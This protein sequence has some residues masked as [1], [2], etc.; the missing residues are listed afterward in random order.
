MVRCAAAALVFAL[1][2]ACADYSTGGRTCFTDSDC[3]IGSTCQ[4]TVCQLGDTPD[5][6]SPDAFSD[7]GTTD[8][9]APSGLA[10]TQGE[11]GAVVLTWDEVPGAATYQVQVDDAEW[12]SV[13][14]DASWTDTE[15][16]PSLP[17]VGTPSASD[18]TNGEGIL[19]ELPELT[20]D[21]NTRSYRVR[22]ADASGAVG[23]ETLP[24][25]GYAEALFSVQ[26][27][28]SSGERDEAFGAIEGATTETYLDRDAPAD[29]ALRWY[30]V[31]WTVEGVTEVSPSD[32]GTRARGLN[33]ACTSDE[34][35]GERCFRGR[36]APGAMVPVPAGSFEMGASRGDPIPE[37]NEAPR[38]EVT[39][40]PSF[41]M[42]EVEV[43]R[44]EWQEVTGAAIG[45]FGCESCPVHN[46]SIYAAAAFANA[47][48]RRDAL[49]ECYTFDPPS[50]ADSLDDWAGGAAGDC[51]TVFSQGTACTGYRLPNEVE[52]EYAYR[53]G[54]SAA[55]HNGAVVR[56]DAQH[57]GDYPDA[58][59]IASYCNNSSADYSNCTQDLAARGGPA[60][61]GVQEVGVRAPN[62]WGLFDM[63]G[64]V[65]EFVWAWFDDYPIDT[66]EERNREA[67][68]PD[69]RIAQR[70][71][72]WL[73]DA[74]ELRAS[75]RREIAVDYRNWDGG[76]RLVRSFPGIE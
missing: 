71:G 73:S 56:E 61:G 54:E 22:A 18:G 57:C 45:F 76:F 21:P 28:R 25:S 10:A 72:A 3:P 75:Y 30:R 50:C 11:I 36:C 5:G 39:V 37:A 12:I 26:W 7:A 65:R 67:L 13:G 52:W 68:R 8:L 35:C 24:V 31:E 33:A 9:D 60:C 62:A 27:Q 44:S 40:E 43:L 41:F 19:L 66:P 20:F 46:V 15:A 32:S 58:A 70:G 48:S 23:R 42:D 64:N 14:G 16:P 53:A 6:G 38:H 74:L 29:G 4:G 17:R 55:L 2:G 34:Q 51:E 59:E 63:A 69:D 49:P 1:V 47:R